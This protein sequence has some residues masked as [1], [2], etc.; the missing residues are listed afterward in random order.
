MKTK[1]ITLFLMTALCIMFAAC[2]SG[3]D[4]ES[5]Y[6]EQP[7]AKPVLLELTE[8]VSTD[9]T[10]ALDLFRT[11]C[12]FAPPAENVFISPLSVSMALNM[13]VNGAEGTTR[14]EMLTALRARGY[15]M[16]DINEY[17]R[18]LRTALLEVDPSTEFSIANSIWYRQGFPV[19]APFLDVNR[20]NYA[21]EINEIDF[22]SPAAVTQINGWCAQKT[23]DKITEIV[24]EISGDAMMYL[25][26]AVYFKGIWVSKFDKKE[27]EK[28]D[29]HLSDGTTR[30]VDMMRQRASFNYAEDE[31]AAYLELPYGN[32]AFSMIVILPHG[33]KTV[34]DVTAQLDSER[35]N[36]R[37]GGLAGREV[38]LYL[39]RFKAE[40]EYKL[41]KN[42][43]PEMGMTVPFSNFANFSGM[44]A[45]SL[46]ISEVIHK[47]YVDV[48]EE[49]T[50]A[51]AVTSVGM[52]T[53]AGPSSPLNFMVDRPFLFVIR[54]RSTGVILFTGRMEKV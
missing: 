12:R 16:D 22:A 14:D 23:K 15:S 41:E 9:N 53:S 2:Q 17:S 45:V 30:K 20:E 44:S 26:N 11:T 31:N 38:N 49:G 4:D 27:T 8:K 46:Q 7:E 24:D 6:D 25:I 50:E 48:N 28:E 34:D 19:E 1:S 5:G 40:L 37:M 35:W 47:T 39:P 32:R 42:V 18:S 3:S 21:A 43:L 13:T 51:A 54:E 29:F 33:D 36:D 52:M 10:F